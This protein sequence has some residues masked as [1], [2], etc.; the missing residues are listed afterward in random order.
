[1]G[2]LSISFDDFPVSA[3][4]EGGRV[5]AD[6]GVK[7]TYYACGG[8]CGGRNMDLPQFEVADLEAVVE[9]GHEVG[10]HTYGHVSALKLS[11]TELRASLVRNAHWMAERL[12]GYRMTTFA[13][14]FGDYTIGA[15]RVIAER[16]AIGRG[17]RTG[18]NRG[19][20]DR[21]SLRAI[22]LETYKLATLD[23]DALVAE[24][25]ARRGWLIAYGH[26]VGDSPTAYGC[27]PEVIDRLITAARRAG[28]AIL[29]VN[30][31]AAAMGVGAPLQA[32][33]PVWARAQR[34]KPARGQ[35]MIHDLGV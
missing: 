33:D 30:A 31:A 14:P 4:T 12:N 17:V 22:G 18:I 3:W 32:Q 9:A 8:L 34:S 10:C 23:F 16:F 26:D 15:K 35:A 13:F 21:T 1:V 2:T 5:L 7:A 28:L 25:A 11:D 20:A 19:V 27:R 29:P 24:T 6:H